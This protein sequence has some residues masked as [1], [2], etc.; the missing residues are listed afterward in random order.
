MWDIHSEW[1][2]TAV[3]TL[4]ASG[5]LLLLVAALSIDIL[6]LLGWE[7]AGSWYR[8]RPAAPLQLKCEWLYR[9]LAHPMY[10]GVLLGFWMA[11]L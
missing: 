7:Q 6:E 11:P 10:V 4:F 3:W 9:Y 2:K 8:G 5:W 1:M